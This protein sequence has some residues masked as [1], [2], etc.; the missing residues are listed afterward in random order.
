MAYDYALVHL[1]FTVPVAALLTLCNFPFL[2]R[3]HWYQ[4]F[5][6]IT[7]AVVAT[8]PWDSYLIRQHVW[9]YPPDA[10]VGP[11]FWAIPA[12]EL[13]F[14]IVQ[15]YITSMLYHLVNKPLLHAAYLSPPSWFRATLHKLVQ[16]AILDLALVGFW[17]V[18]NG[19]PGTYLGLILAWAC[20][21]ALLTW[22][23]G[24]LFM[25]SLPFT[26]T[27]LPILLSTMYLWAV[28]EGAL[29]RGTWS[30]ESGTKLGTILVG[31]LDI[32]EAVFFLATNVLIVFGLG[33]FDN[34]L[35]VIDAF[36]D[37]FKSAPECPSPVMLVEALYMKWTE[38][39]DDRVTGILEAVERLCRKSRSFYLASST[40]TGRLRIDLVLLYSYCRMADDLVD[41]PPQGLTTATWIG[42]LKD[43]LDLVYKPKQSETDPSVQADM[44]RA[45][46]ESEFPAS[47]RSALTH[48]PT[49]LLPPEPFYLL[50][51]GFKTDSGFRLN[52]DTKERRHFPIANED[53][54]REYGSRVAGTVGELCLALITH[55]SREPITPTRQ[56]SVAKAA[57]RMGIALQYVNIARDIAVDA[58]MGRVYLPTTWL[59]EVGLTPEVV[60]DTI[61]SKD[62]QRQDRLARLVSL[63]ERLL[64]TAFAIYTEARPTMDWLPDESRRPMI[65]AVESYM[66]IGRVLREQQ[67]EGALLFEVV[68]AGRPRRATVSKWRR[69]KVALG[70]LIYA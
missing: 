51:E 67:E 33:A 65:V 69:L 58:A 6:L 39:R 48:L 38:E 27:L 32:E 25:V 13:F 31:S 54:L 70:A 57:A 53:D 43:H 28:D 56:K 12:E 16:V 14:F 29:R 20:P 34:A 68:E 7:I 9:T 30:I 63:R 4:T 10:I 49:S 41:E 1:K 61:M 64:N 36:P 44:I 40:F 59:V 17:L 22:S 62:D 55:H 50:L 2:T 35:A 21:F 11:T 45:Y 52:N 23:L 18:S 42:R 5:I 15:T 46:I 8:I 37:A 19:G 24:G 66:E 60:V 3:R 47:A 26:S